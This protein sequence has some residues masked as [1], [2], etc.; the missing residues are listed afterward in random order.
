MDETAKQKQGDIWSWI[1]IG[2]VHAAVTAALFG[3][4]IWERVHSA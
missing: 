3:P 4:L 2:L 1:V